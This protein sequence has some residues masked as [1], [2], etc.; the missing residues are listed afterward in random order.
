MRALTVSA[1][2]LFWVALILATPGALARAIQQASA[3]SEPEA[4]CRALLSRDFSQVEDAPTEVLAASYQPSAGRTPA[5]C[6]VEGYVA[7][8]VG[9]EIR[10]PVA[11]WNGALL[12]VGSGGWG[13]EMY[14]FFCEGPL[15]KGYACIASDMGHKGASSSGLWAA[16]NPQAQI[17]FAYRATHVTALAGKAIVTAF[18]DTAPARALMFGCS[19]GGYQGMVEAQRFPWDFDG[20]VA[21][22]PDMTGEADLS[23]R[24][25][26]NTRAFT[27]DDG[28]AVLSA[29]EQQL[30]HQAVLAKCDMTDGIRD[31]IVGDPV[32]C[33][34]DPKVLECRPGHSTN[35]LA[36]DKVAAVSRIY[37]GPV[38]S[39]GL[40]L[41]TRGVFPGS[42][43]DWQASDGAEV[44]E[45]FKYLV[46]GGG[47]G[48]K[49]RLGDFNFDHD[50]RRL[51]LG[52]LYSDNNPDLR[53][54]KAA[55]GKLLVAQGGN[56]AVEIPGAAVDYYQTVIRTMGGRA[57]TEN[58]FRLFIV[59]GMKHCSGGSGAFA[60]DYLGA[61]ETWVAQGKAP[62]KLMGAHVDSQYLLRL[63]KD[64]S[65]SEADR[66]WWAA[67][68]LPLP[69]EH[70]V[71]VT[72]SR[73]VYP[74]PRVAV[75]K[76]RGD[77]NDAENYSAADSG[78]AD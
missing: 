13:G 31:G 43:L 25:V 42:E 40:R 56:D 32:G 74:Y 48:P 24:I 51:G 8:Q 61:L 1:A 26:W 21:I 47:A 77:P 75:Y 70:D 37:S 36:P 59:P 9:F 44:A 73:P 69:L 71:P 72:F 62:D 23:M 22:A 67:L 60:I 41:S 28:K 49:W 45:F 17:D 12:E 58:F 54:F 10:L 33:E 52:A 65:R 50:Y 64:P 38:D 11:G 18:Y 68:Q 30:L 7:P 27:D 6:R 66:I 20:I 55:G 19:T 57:A 15:R 5:Y 4:Q 14:L 53:Q 2:A 46:P 16:N 78:G 29:S 3:A 34:F 63:N 76:G 39:H 35:C